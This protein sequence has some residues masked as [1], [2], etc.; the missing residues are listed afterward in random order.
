[1]RKRDLF[2]CLLILLLMLSG[3]VGC[4]QELDSAKTNPTRETAI[5]NDPVQDHMM[6]YWDDFNFS[7]SLAITNPDIAEQ[8]LVDFI[9]ACTKLPEAQ[10]SLAIKNMLSRA[11]SNAFAFSSFTQQLE[12]YLYD[13]NSPMRNDALYQPVLEFLLDSTRLDA[14]SRLKNQHRLE[15]A[16]KNKLGNP[17]NDFCFQL[18]NGAEQR[19]YEIDAA[20]TV[21][22]F[23]EPDCDHCQAAIA[24]LRGSQHFNQLLNTGKL[25]ILAV[26]AGKSYTLWKNYQQQLP[27]SWI[28]GF[29]AEN[30]I[31]RERIYDLRGS[32]TIYLLNEGKQVILKDTGLAT[33]LNISSPTS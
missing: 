24:E 20:L 15:L 9:A 5:V 30:R 6:H 25:K 21:L 31:R 1:M 2:S 33:L 8:A 12:H 4:V 22:F 14:P 19:L 23:Y 7:D 11:K 32:P 13:P 17:A 27:A 29:D 18:P 16:L 10:Q 28:N 26:Y 3:L